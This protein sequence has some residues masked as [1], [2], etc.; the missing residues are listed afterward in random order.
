MMRASLRPVSW[1]GRTEA[2]I[3]IPGVSRTP[4]S[5]KRA[6][7]DSGSMTW[8]AEARSAWNHSASSVSPRRSAGSGVSPT[9]ATARPLARSRKAVAS[10][11]A[12]CSSMARRAQRRPG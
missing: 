11:L 3:R 7:R 8:E 12:S 1:P 2:R 6:S 9:I 10:D 4:A 5:V